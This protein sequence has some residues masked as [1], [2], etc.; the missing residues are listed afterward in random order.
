LGD[1]N[2]HSVNGYNPMKNSRLQPV[3]GNMSSL[4]LLQSLKDSIVSQA[5]VKAVYGDPISAHGKTV[6]P[7]AKMIYGYGAGAGT[8]GVGDSRAK[9]E[10]G[11]G[12]GAALA[13]PVGVVEIN[14][15]QTRFVPITDRR[16]LA[17]AVM[18]GAGVGIFLSWLKRR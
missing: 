2:R 17:G 11:G 16:K 15:Q 12:G 14:E 7:V 5:S 3:G 10:G 9:G 1:S 8:G 13:I 18:I 4:A 6:I